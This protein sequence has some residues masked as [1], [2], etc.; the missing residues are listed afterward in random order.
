M[1][2][3]APSHR[4][5]SRLGRRQS[6]AGQVLRAELPSLPADDWCSGDTA[7]ARDP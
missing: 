1:K 4:M 3:I 5:D 2:S 6:F 7:L